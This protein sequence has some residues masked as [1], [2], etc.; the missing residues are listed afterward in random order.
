LHPQSFFKGY[1]YFF[2]KKQQSFVWL[3]VSS[4]KIVTFDKR[5]LKLKT[6]Q[7]DN[8]PS[9]NLQDIF[10]QNDKT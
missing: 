9:E 7:K 4:R 1:T 5:I 2:D 3:K 8:F 6:S 10:D